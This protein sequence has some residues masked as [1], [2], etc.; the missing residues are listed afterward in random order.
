[1]TIS[2]GYY[3]LKNVDE[4]PVPT[5]ILITGGNDQM[6]VQNDTFSAIKV[7]ARDQFNAGLPNATVRFTVPAGRGNWTGSP[8]STLSRDVVT[9]AN[10]D[11]TSPTFV[12]NTVLGALPVTVAIVSSLISGPVN[13]TVVDVATPTSV[14][15]QSG[16]GQI[17]AV[18]TQFNTA[19]TAKVT[20]A[21]GDPLSGINV[22]FT[23]PATGQSCGFP[24][25]NT[26]TVATNA[27]GLA[28]TVKPT[29]N[30]NTGAYQVS[31]AVAGVA[32]NALFSL[33]NGLAY[34]PEVCSPLMPFVTGVTAGANTTPWTN[35]QRAVDGNATGAQLNA[36]N[37]VSN[38]VLQ[39][40][41]TF[42][43]YLAAIDDNAK[44]TKIQLY[45]EY[46][47]TLVNLNISCAVFVDGANKMISFN[48]NSSSANG[49]YFAQ[50]FNQVQTTGV[51]ITAAQMKN[52]LW[53]VNFAPGQ[54]GN[55]PVLNLRNAKIAMCYQNPD[56]PPPQ[57]I[58]PLHVCEV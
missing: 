3:N 5:S 11:A 23:A 19:L 13:W 2:G 45:F 56:Y 14:I 57:I 51:G 35:P 46:K 39:V 36:A 25:S 4:L 15:V 53:A 47:Y 28:S 49:V 54:T 43:A 17:Q 37:N 34:L 10:G 41:G 27:S 55:V 18:S 52:G 32:A 16:S 50:T 31:A 20:N 26:T 44:F 30:A 33:N 8:G 12:A 1:L 9:D 29:A 6:R 40:S 21:L 42:A 38:Q 22:V 7:K 48:V 24:V 58:P